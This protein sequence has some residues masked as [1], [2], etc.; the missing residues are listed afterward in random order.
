[1]P[2]METLVMFDLAMLGVLKLDAR[3]TNAELAP[4]WA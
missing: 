1:M 3:L 4:A 2:I